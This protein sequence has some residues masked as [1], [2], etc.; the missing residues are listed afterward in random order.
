MNP[1]SARTRRAPSPR[2]TGK[3]DPVI[4]APAGRSRI[5]RAA[6]SSQCG[7]GAKSNTGGVPQARTTRL[8]LASPSG[9]LLRGEI[10]DRERPA[11]ELG[12]DLAEAGVER[13][14]LIA[15]SLE[16]GHQVLRGLLGLLPPRDLL[17]RGIALGLERLGLHQQLTALAVELED[18]VEQRPEGGVATTEQRGA[19]PLGVLAQALEVDHGRSVVRQ[20]GQEVFVPAVVVDERPEGDRAVLEAEDLELAVLGH[21]ERRADH[22]RAHDE[23][24]ARAPLARPNRSRTRCWG[25]W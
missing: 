14:D 23:P 6:P 11:L 24:V 22:A 1:L 17:A 16:P 21:A 2:K 10:G 20:A 4:L 13:L 8:A 25:R 9:D 19:A 5:P 3:P 12:L 15:R 7:R 18:G